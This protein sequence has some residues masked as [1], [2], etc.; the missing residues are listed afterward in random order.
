LPEIIP[1]AGIALP[2]NIGLT[3]HASLGDQSAAFLASIK[4]DED[5]LVNLGTGGF[6]MRSLP[7]NV[8]SS[9]GYLNTL[10]YQESCHRSHFAIEGT[11][12]SIAAA[13]EPY[14]TSQCML[15]DLA[16]TDIYCLAEPSGLGAPYFRSDLGLMFS[17]SINHLT[18]QQIAT[19][20]LEAIIFRVVRIVDD[21]TALAPVNRVYLSGGLSKSSALKHGIAQCVTSDLYLLPE[22]DASLLGVALLACGKISSSA[23]VGEKIIATNNPKLL[24]KYRDWKSWLD[25]MLQ[26]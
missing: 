7:S 12:N 25:E 3:L 10:L 21:F 16:C 11:I 1:S 6:V 9:K 4:N 17:Q 5:V 15:S 24:L 23:D 13:L 18:T 20:L 14:P 26:H 2:L 8:R 22:H 19:L